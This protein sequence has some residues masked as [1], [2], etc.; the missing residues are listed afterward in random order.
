MK[1]IT[2]ILLFFLS[3]FSFGYAQVSA[4]SFAQ[5]ND[6]YT[7][8]T[9]G[10]VLGTSTTTTSFD[11]QVWAIA[12]GS[13]PFNFNF[14]GGNYTGCNVN[15]NGFITFGTTAPSSTLTSPISST[16]AYNG[17][18]S[19]W[20]GDLCGVYVAGLITGETRWEVV[21]T[22][23]NREFVVQF[24]N[25]RPTYSSSSTNIPFMNFQIRLI[26][27]SNVVKIVYG[28]NG[29]AIGSTSSS[30]SRQIGLR[31]TTNADYNNRLNSS[32]VLFTASTAGTA[33]S[34]TQAYNTTVAT[35]GMPSNG[36][37]Y[38]WTPPTLCTGTPVAGT[39]APASQ[40][41]VTG[42]ASVAL[43]ITGQ[44]TGVSGLTYQWEESTDGGSNWANAVG[45]TGATTLSYT[46]PVYAGTPIQ[47]R[48]KITCTAS[49]LFGYSSVAS[50]VSC[51]AVT[52]LPWT[53][54]FDGLTTLGTA[55]FPTC[56]FKEIGDWS[57]SNATTYNTARSGANYIRNA[58]ASTDE[59]MWT[60]GFDL[61][62]GTSYDFSAFVQGDGGTGWIV[63]M[64]YNTS[65]SSVGAT[66]LGGSYN[67]PGTGT[68]AIQPYSEMK[69]TFVP[70]SS[71]TY[72]FAVRVNQPST[73]PW[74]VAFDDFKLELT[75]A[76]PSPSGLATSAVT[77][78]SATITWTA[79][80]GNYQYVIDQVATNPAGAGTN[81]AGEIYNAASLSPQTT[82]YFH[83]RTDC[84]AG[85]YSAWSVISFTTPAAPP[86]NDECSNAVALTVNPDFSCG[87]QTPG[88]ILGATASSVDAAA[89]FGTE[90]DDVWFSFV[91]TATSH[92]IQL[93]NVTGSTTD[94]YH[95]LWTGADCNSLTLVAGSCSDPDTSNP[96]GLVIGQTY[97]VR[98]NSYGSAA[99]T[100]TFNICIGT[101]P[102]PPANDD[103]ANAIAIGALPY[104]NTQDA[105]TATNNAGYISTCSGTSGMN[106]GVWYTVVG[107]GA[108]ITININNVV[109][110]D[111]ELAVYTG[112]CGA[113]TCVGSVDAG[114]TGGSESYTITGSTIGTTYYINIGY[115][116]GTSN[117]PEG[118]FAINVTTNLSNNSFDLNSFK[119]YPN[120]VTNVLNLSYSSEISSVEVFNM[121]GQ[122]VLVKEL[123][124]AQ[125][126]I[127]M[128]N[129]NAGN[130]IVKV[131][132]DGLTKTIKVIKQ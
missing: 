25:W 129:L 98:V 9:G 28:S 43:T 37:T 46:P 44:T 118:P 51:A 6:T 82:Y 75:P 60:V 52:S 62:A 17:A 71:G 39:S 69:R 124:V 65:A 116:S 53:E 120:P 61:T 19:A 50:L 113:F 125:G 107:N 5:T 29:Y 21:G 57:S 16:A 89:C 4:Y 12:D 97:Y 24:K 73:A 42:Q 122:K 127:D 59:Y 86:V 100:T 77:S 74:Y 106:D 119:A 103:C 70:S 99:Q 27:T 90:N 14:N 18:V 84:G 36:L 114:S 55:N 79:T 87:V 58:W 131:T 91:A 22:A 7:E 11:S 66:Q 2:W 123:N 38:T 78:T 13:I 31:G 93:N 115:W 20:A 104:A 92:R 109:G 10:T 112:S 81:L 102:P 117:S 72:Y 23:P 1:K 54:N 68:I 63:D 67:V 126:Q 111:P 94:M 41:L 35:P 121:L 33:N 56:W 32:S 15:S 45:G 95:S 85:T 101:P 108:D 48:L 47:Y 40:T 3:C 8:I 110:W 49:G 80:S 26:E 132:A 34:S 130:Y 96:G 30:G 105:T 128:S 83:V 76:C 88:T 64:F